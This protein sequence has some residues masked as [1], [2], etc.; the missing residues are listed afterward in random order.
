MFLIANLKGAA[1]NEAETR[2]ELIDPALKAA[3]RG[4]VAGSRV[5]REVITP[6]RLRAAGIRVPHTVFQPYH[7]LTIHRERVFGRANKW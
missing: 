5:R 7:G 3:G 2:A 1:L 6:G 4:V